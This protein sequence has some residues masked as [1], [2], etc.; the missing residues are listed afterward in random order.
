MEG[1][2]VNSLLKMAEDFFGT[3]YDL[4]Q[5]PATRET[6][7]KLQ[8]IHPRTIAYQLVDGRLTGWAVAIPTSKNLM[9]DF[10]RGAINERQLLGMTES[11]NKFETVYLAAAF[12]LPEYRRRGCVQRMFIEAIRS[13]PLA[14]NPQL[15]YWPFT[16]EGRKLA[17][18]IGRHLEMEIK[19]RK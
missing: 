3:K 17:N 13:I 1:K 10:L 7:R 19:E 11:K 9:K 16:V 12:I 2:I 18:G 15:F 4:D 6:I 8:K 14:P 5:M